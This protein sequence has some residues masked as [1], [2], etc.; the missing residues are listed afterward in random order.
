MDEYVSDLIALLLEI[1]NLFLIK[2]EIK[3]TVKDEGTS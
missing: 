1:A 2:L 3:E